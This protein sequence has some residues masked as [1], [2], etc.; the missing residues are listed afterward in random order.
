MEIEKIKLCLSGAAIGAF[1]LFGIGFGMSGWVLGGTAQEQ[2][3]I[4]VIERLTPICVAQF[5][6][7]PMMAQKLASLNKLSYRE[8]GKFVAGQ[9][10]ATM[11]GASAPDA[12]VAEKCADKISG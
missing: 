7:D 1:L 3:E 5:K 2:S 12:A 6:Q 11:P 9:G 8:H 4:A 10:W